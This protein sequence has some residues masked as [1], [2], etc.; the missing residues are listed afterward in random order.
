MVVV[1]VGSV[2]VVSVGMVVSM[3]KKRV[4]FEML[5]LRFMFVFLK[6][7]EFF[8]NFSFFLKDSL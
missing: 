2:V 5:A 3:K 8:I 1:V 4:C 6:K 7:M